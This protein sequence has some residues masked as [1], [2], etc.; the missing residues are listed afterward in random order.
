MRRI[1]QFTLVLGAALLWACYSGVAG[2]A[3]LTGTNFEGE[4]L[5]FNSTNVTSCPSDVPSGSTCYSCNIGDGHRGECTAYCDSTGICHCEVEEVCPKGTTTSGGGCEVHS[6]SP[7]LVETAPSGN[8]WE[9]AWSISD[10]TTLQV[11]TYVQCVGNVG[12]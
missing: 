5:N 9:C 8:G 12:G 2:A 7:N 10:P 3:G 6:G 1:T 4:C 11:D